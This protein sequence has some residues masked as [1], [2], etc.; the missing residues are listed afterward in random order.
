MVAVGG[1]HSPGR[2]PLGLLA[3]T[4]IT[5]TPSQKDPAAA[6][7][8]LAPVSVRGDIDLAWTRIT[9][10]RAMVASTLDSTVRSGALRSIQV[11]G[12]P[13]NSSVRLMETWLRLR[14][15]VEATRRDDPGTRG[16]A[17]ITAGTPDGDIVI[18]R[19]DHDRVT[20]TRPGWAEPQ[21]VTMERRE[22]VATLNEELRRLTPDLVY[23]EVLT[24]FGKDASAPATP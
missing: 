8:A 14:L 10:W 2:G 17:S 9:L 18:A 11:V 22:P 23:Q 6:L 12:E 20:V 15:G 19:H 7:A 13:R 4:R 24:A 3:T 1:A 5:N 21:V 16:I